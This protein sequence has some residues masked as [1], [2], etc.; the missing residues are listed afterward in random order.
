MNAATE[1]VLWMRIARRTAALER[2]LRQ[3]RSLLRGPPQITLA[4]GPDGAHELRVTM[5]ATGA[6]AEQLRREFLAL[7]DVIDAVVLPA[8]GTA[9]GREMALV[10]IEAPRDGAPDEPG[11]GEPEEVRVVNRAGELLVVEV[12]GTASEVERI[13]SRWSAEGRIHGVTRTGEI[14]LPGDPGTSI[15]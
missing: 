1:T 15:Q 9:P 12:T 5:S 14:V 7:H 4:R 8:R 6:R 13:L 3:L 2:V 11:S 10:R